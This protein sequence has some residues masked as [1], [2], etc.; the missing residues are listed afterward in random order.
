M[1]TQNIVPFAPTSRTSGRRTSSSITVRDENLNVLRRAFASY[2]CSFPAEKQER[3]LRYAVD[4]IVAELI[5][6]KRT[7]VDES[8]LDP[9]S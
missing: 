1:Q 2:L 9:A 8:T 6:T 5:G 3:A 4:I 7:A